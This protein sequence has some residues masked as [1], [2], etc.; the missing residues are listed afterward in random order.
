M[1]RIKKKIKRGK[2]PQSFSGVEETSS[3][4]FIHFSVFFLKKKK[5]EK[6]L[7]LRL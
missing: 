4:Y 5:K 7:Q 3:D 1:S 2:N 6:E